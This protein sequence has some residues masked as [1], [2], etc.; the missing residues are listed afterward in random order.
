MMSCSTIYVQN[1]EN[2]TCIASTKK[3]GYPHYFKKKKTKQNKKQQQQQQPAILFHAARN[4]SHT[5]AHT[6]R[7][8]QWK[9][10]FNLPTFTIP[11]V[12]GPEALD[13]SRRLPRGRMVVD[14]KEQGF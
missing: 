14:K 1:V 7:R 11:P 4:T 9:V 13:F 3:P 6:H 12:L 5:L 2:L 8:K 10:I